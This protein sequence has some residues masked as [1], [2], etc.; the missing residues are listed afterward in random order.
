M[1]WAAKEILAA[2]ALFS[3]AWFICFQGSR[4]IQVHTIRHSVSPLLLGIESRL[5]LFTTF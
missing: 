1:F 4:C 5:P 2:S 3:E